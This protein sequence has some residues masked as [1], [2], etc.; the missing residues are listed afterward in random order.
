MFATGLAIVALKT[1]L[2]CFAYRRLTAAYCWAWQRP[3]SSTERAPIFSSFD[4][5]LTCSVARDDLEVKALGR[6]KKLAEQ[7]HSL[8]ANASYEKTFMTRSMFADSLL[9]LQST[10]SSSSSSVWS[11]LR[12]C[13]AVSLVLI[14]HVFIFSSRM[15]IVVLLIRSLG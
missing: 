7:I 2:Q 11:K 5:C 4:L 3:T 12:L 14:V 9:S 15:E 10:N 6:R 13:S 1:S 8:K